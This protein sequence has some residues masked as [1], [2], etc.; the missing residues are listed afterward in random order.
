VASAAPALDQEREQRL[1]VGA[2]G[3]RHELAQR[4]EPVDVDV[5][6]SGV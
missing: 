4:V 5:H 2:R 3:R 1:E 6:V